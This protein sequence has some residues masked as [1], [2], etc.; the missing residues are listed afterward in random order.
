MD[1]HLAAFIS[2]SAAALLWKFLLTFPSTMRKMF[3]GLRSATGSV[4]SSPMSGIWE[5]RAL[6]STQF[7]ACKNCFVSKWP[8]CCEKSHLFL[9]LFT[10]VITQEDKDLSALIQ[11]GSLVQ[12]YPKWLA[13]PKQVGM[14]DLKSNSHW[15]MF[16]AHNLLPRF[17]LHLL[18]LN[19]R[20][21]LKWDIVEESTDYYCV[22]KSLTSHSEL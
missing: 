18:A 16:L 19:T 4:E 11:G 9:I 13:T 12:I 20:G 5:D 1:G 6:P 17:T 14:L 3:P 8:G 7:F 10:E 15:G 22:N 21:Y 2:V